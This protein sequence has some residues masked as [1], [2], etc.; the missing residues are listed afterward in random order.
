MFLQDLYLFL[1]VTWRC[2]KF[3]PWDFSHLKVVQILPWCTGP[4]SGQKLMEEIFFLFLFQDQ[5]E[6]GTFFFFYYLRL[7]G[8]VPGS[9]EGV[10]GGCHLTSL[11]L[12]FFSSASVCIKTNELKTQSISD[13]RSSSGSCQLLDLATSLDSSFCFIFSFEEILKCPAVNLRRFKNFLSR[14]FRH[15][16]QEFF[17]NYS[18]H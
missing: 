7:W 6:I 5:G 11:E 18:L 12:G 9:T 3:S 1:P 16:S 15:L 13:S 8:L 17:S 10:A 4:V 2:F 14:T